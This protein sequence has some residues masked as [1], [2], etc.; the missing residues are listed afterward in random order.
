SLLTSSYV[1]H[2]IEL[3]TPIGNLRLCMWFLEGFEVDVARL[4]AEQADIE[5]M[6][7]NSAEKND[8]NT[9]WEFSPSGEYTVPTE[10]MDVVRVRSRF[11][12]FLHRLTQGEKKKESPL[13]PTDDLLSLSGERLTKAVPAPDWEQAATLFEQRVRPWLETETPSTS[14]VF[15][16]A[17]PYSGREE[18]LRHWAGA[19]KVSVLK[20]PTTEAILGDSSK[21]LRAWPRK[22]PW[23]LPQ[24]ERCFLRHASGL[25]LVRELLSGMMSGDLGRGIVGCDS[26]AW[27]YLQHVLPNRSSFTLSA[28]AFDAQRLQELFSENIFDQ[29]GLRARFRQADNGAYLF[30]E[31]QEGDD[32]DAADGFWRGL[33]ARSRGNVG[34]AGAYWK[35]ALRTL[36]EKELGEQEAE[37]RQSELEQAKPG[38]AASR[39]A[40]SRQSKWAT[41]W[42]TPW[43]DMLQPALPKGSGESE[44]FVL[45]ALLLHGGLSEVGLKRTLPFDRASITEV[46]H[47]L[48]EREFVARTDG[49]WY[50]TAYGYPTVRAALKTS[51]YLCDEF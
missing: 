47:F 2:K 36:P 29:H 24:L 23:V 25:G 50:V 40:A 12:G 4:P 14:V 10:S 43:E 20:E 33:A 3:A 38:Y 8:S 27:A 21:W 6:S 17:P 30:P 26:W 35:R 28:K 13:D 41:I 22:G 49:R 5:T 51:D 37:S 34:V 1:F 19:N 7:T 15:Y 32:V 31:R 18:I 48:A 45:Q 39:H 9:Y 16:V 46:L 11:L 44:L 42:V